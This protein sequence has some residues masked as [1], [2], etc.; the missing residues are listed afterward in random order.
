MTIT[1]DSVV[2]AAL[3]GM[4]SANAKFEDWS[5][6]SWVS[7][8]GVEGFMVAHI[9]AAL[10]RQQDERESL[11]LEA[12]FEEIRE[13]SGAARHPGRPRAVMQGKRRADIAL[14]DRRGRTVHVLE[15]KRKWERAGVF[16]DIERLLAL[17]NACAKQKNGSLKH[18]FLVLPIVEWAETPK[19]IK[20][21]VRSR[22][23]NIEADIRTKFSIEE[24]TVEFRMGRMRRYPHHYGETG[25]W[26]WAGFCATFSI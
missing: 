5:R 15:V 7:D 14:F 11:L 9:A 18:G 25:E 23:R 22:A 8:Y 1:K 6:G 2:R 26:A 13:C 17:L 19:E 20:V 3:Q 12:P 24:P 21:Q 16:R 10:R 4:A